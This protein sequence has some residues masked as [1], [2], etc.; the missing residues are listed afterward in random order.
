MAA[1]LSHRPPE[2]PSSSVGWLKNTECTTK[3][4]RMAC[5][6]ALPTHCK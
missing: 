3:K 6:M 2:L 1:P 4:A 5:R